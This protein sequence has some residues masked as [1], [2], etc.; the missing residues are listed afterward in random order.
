MFNFAVFVLTTGLLPTLAVATFDGNINYASPSRRHSGLGV[1]VPR[2]SRRSLKRSAVAYK[3]DELSFTHG[4]ASGDP[5]SDSL[6]LWTRVAPSPAS[7]ASNVT[8]EGT[9]PLY[10]H[11]TETY[12]RADPSPIC[13]EW[14]VYDVDRNIVTNGEAYTTSDID[15]TIKI[16]ATGLQPFTYYNYQFTI[17]GSDKTSPI[18]R[19]KTAPPTDADVSEV[20]LAV[21]SCSNYRKWS[22][23][24]IDKI[25]LTCLQPMVT[26]MPTEM[27]LA[28][29]SMTS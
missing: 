28:K 24:F 27:P 13:V 22:A 4:V 11:D 14:K 20:K 17:C 21:F 8:V 1:D 15:Y 3:A 26:S 23:L 29:T 19:A 5:Y 6:I 12:I 25:A 7:D 10:N 2:V 9:V 18:G 16:E